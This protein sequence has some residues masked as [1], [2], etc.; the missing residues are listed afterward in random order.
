GE[1]TA[2]AVGR[3]VGDALGDP[4]PR[5]PHGHRPPVHGDP[6]R[7]GCGDPGEQLLQLGLAV[8][9]DAGDAEHLAGADLQVERLEAAAE[10]PSTRRRTS[11][12]R[13]LRDA[14]GSTGAE[15]TMSVARLAR[16]WADTGSPAHT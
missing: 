6:A 15:P 4:L 10:A 1:C 7:V 9:V 12:S 11:P 3:D 13:T 16:S 8:A 2:V 5:R 14:A